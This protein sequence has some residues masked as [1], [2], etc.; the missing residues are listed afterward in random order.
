M[1]D[2]LLSASVLLMILAGAACGSLTLVDATQ[3]GCSTAALRGNYGSQRNG[4]TAPDIPWTS[5]GLAVFDGHGNILG[6]QAASVNGV[7]SSVT[8]QVGTYTINPDCSGSESDA[9]DKVIG[10]LV[11]VHG[12]DQ[13][14][15]MST[16]PGNNTTVHYERINGPCMNSM[17]TGDYGF[18]RN[19]QTGPGLSLLA[20]R[21][22]TFDGVANTVTVQT[23][24]RNGVINTVTNQIGTYLINPDCTGTQ[25][26]PAAAGR[27]FA[28]KIK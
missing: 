7:F 12:G 2:V 19:G 10:T 5:V 22:T 3:T 11:V 23:V 13:V 14:I 15:G 27:I 6:H 4:Q 8:N 25:N 24:N 28:Q 26:D 18:Q 20:V 17:L 21:I 9:S 16:I 1:K